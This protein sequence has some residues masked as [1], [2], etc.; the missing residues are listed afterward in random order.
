VEN[1]WGAKID[2]TFSANNKIYGSFAT[3]TLGVPPNA[4]LPGL[5]E[6][7][8]TSKSGNDMFRLD[9]DYILRPN[10]V[11]HAVFGYNRQDSTS[12][13]VGCPSN[14]W[15]GQNGFTGIPANGPDPQFYFNDESNGGGAGGPA[16]Y[17]MSNNFEA[18]DTL[19]WMK[20]KHSVKFGFQYIHFAINAWSPGNLSGQ[21]RFNSP[22]TAL[23][24]TGNGGSGFASFLY[25]WVDYATVSVNIAEEAQRSATYA[26]FVQDDWKVT[27]KLTINAGLRY[28]LSTPFT[29]N[30][31]AMQ[32]ETDTIGNAAAGNL[33]GA[34][35]AATPGER[36]DAGIWGDGFGPRLGL[37]YALNDK[38]VIR[39]SYGLIV[40]SASSARVNWGMYQQGFSATNNLYAST[41]AITPAFNL[42]NGW[43]ASNFASPPFTAQQGF[44]EQAVN[45]MEHGDSKQPYMQQWTFDIQRQL[46]SNMLLD[47]SY[48]GV[49][50]THLPSWDVPT[51]NMPPGYLAYGNTLADNLGTPAV[52]GLAPITA[53]PVDPAT[54]NHFPFAGF[55]SAWGKVNNGSAPPL[56]QALVQFPQYG[57]IVKDTET[58]GDSTWNALRI[59]LSKHFSNGLS[60]LVSYTW[61]KD[62][63]DTS[64]S[65]QDTFESNVQDEWDTKLAK[66][67]SENDVPQNLV[68]SYSYELPFGPGKRFVNQHGAVGK[69]VGGWKIT[70]V[71]HYQSGQAI[72]IWNTTSTC[73]LE[74]SY[75]GF[76]N[77]DEVPGV[78]IFGAGKSLWGHGFDPNN[79]ADLW[80]N[81]A[82]ITVP[83]PYTFGTAP[84]D[85]GNLRAPSFIDEDFSIW[86][87]TQITERVRLEFHAD[88]INAFNRTQFSIGDSF[89]GSN[90]NIWVIGWPGFG[91]LTGQ[92]N[93]PRNIQLGMKLVF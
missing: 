88:F 5:L 12:S 19:A 18:N 3:N 51:N 69:V 13:C 26:G 71:Q 49:K 70:G 74:S 87:N 72:S 28:D 4:Q 79:P 39:S 84:Q 93:F 68:I 15:P 9:E 17:S 35:V 41:G 14:G 92:S 80:G 8:G 43:P 60:F 63:S 21:F 50:A 33:P 53:L 22:E 81:P 36:T 45:E 37:A 38:T 75:C 67:L 7:L 86:K 83:A 73:R 42:A 11:N 25:G 30:R 2:H 90:Y 66:G 20:G 48:I 76:Q 44:L 10:L 47:V 46:P 89:G 78:P 65:T 85:F 61:S 91:Q 40:G 62:L 23:P 64:D 59:N 56:S 31:N 57:Q 16:S 58:A 6:S 52:Q 27:R 34:M 32:W 24:D 55:E 29:D 1:E 82:A 54:G 77:V